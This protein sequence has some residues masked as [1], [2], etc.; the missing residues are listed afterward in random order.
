MIKGIIL[1]VDGV[2]VGEKIGFN[3]PYPD[4][5]VIQRLK[6]IREKGI[7]ISLCTAKPYRS[8]EKI[9]S[10][11]GLSNLHITDG[12]SVII[13]PI[14]HEVLEKHVIDKLESL[15]ILNICLRNDIYT[16]FYSVDNYFIQSNQKS[17]LT[18]IHAHVLQMKPEIVSSLIEEAEKQEIV[19]MMP[20]AK[21][22]EDK[23]RVNQ[24]LEPF[25][26]KVT[27]SWGVHPIALPYLFAI[28]TPKNVSKKQAAEK[29]ISNYNLSNGELLAIGDSKSD[30]QFIEICNFA[31]SVEN[32][33]DELKQLIKT[34]EDK[35]WFV[36]KSVDENGIL[37]I[38]DYFSL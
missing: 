15:K 30:W 1:D 38:F 25:I 8:V 24:L 23:E 34:K 17:E 2:I 5:K 16:E 14:N 13:N 37:D 19:K 9:I 7:V 36:G 12:G 29:I 18:N 10:D 27:V 26:D 28:I 21:N 3:S 11:S 6:E 33:A 22:E 35:N 32:G 4:P 20:I 31:G